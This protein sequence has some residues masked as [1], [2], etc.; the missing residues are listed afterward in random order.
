MHSAVVKPADDRFKVALR[1]LPPLD[2]KVLGRRS[3]PRRRFNP[4]SGDPKLQFH[5][6]WPGGFRMS[7]PSGSG[8]LALPPADWTI[9]V[10][11]P[12]NVSVGATKDLSFSASSAVWCSVF[13]SIVDLV[14]VG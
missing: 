13:D 5:P 9:S 12:T 8:A 14:I 10:T 6:G 3:F 11:S 7:G 2:G 1:R 4:E